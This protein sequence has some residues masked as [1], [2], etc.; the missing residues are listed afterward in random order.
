M[1]DKSEQQTIQT[2]G[3][4][5]VRW[6]TLKKPSTP[7]WLTAKVGRKGVAALFAVVL[8]TGLAAGVTMSNLAG[9][10]LEG[11]NIGFSATD[12]TVQSV[13]TDIIDAGEWSLELVLENLGLTQH[14]AEVSV[15]AV[16]AAGATLA[17]EQQSV[18]VLEVPPTLTVTFSLSAPDIVA[19][20]YQFSI[21]VEQTS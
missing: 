8:L 1:E 3:S 15:A 5:L 10:A 17:F 7:G 4:L 11:F 20:T 16:D 13:S 18:I 14:G 19:Q 12:L 9:P 6:E 21:F 2:I